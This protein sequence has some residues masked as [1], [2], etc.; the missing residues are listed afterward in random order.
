[1]GDGVTKISALYV[2]L[3]LVVG[4]VVATCFELTYHI[5]LAIILAGGILFLVSYYRMGA[6]VV[7]LLGLGAFMMSLDGYGVEPQ[8]IDSGGFIASLSHAAS[9]RLDA[10]ELSPGA[11]S[12][13]GALSL[14]ERWMLSAQELS[15]Y[16]RSGT[17]HFL[18][19]SGLHVAIVF[20]LLNSL[21]RYVALL[22]DGHL[23]RGVLS[24]S[25]IWLYAFVVGLPESVVRA[26]IMFTF[27]AMARSLSLPYV[28]LNVLGAAVFVMVI[29]SPMVVW[30][31]GFQLSVIAVAAIFLWA[32]P[33]CRAVEF[34]SPVA[35]WVLS[36]V[37]ISVC[38]TV[39]LAPLSALYFHYIPILGILFTPLFMLTAMLI[40][41]LCLCW[42]MVPIS[43]LA[44][45]VRLP[46]ELAAM[47]QNESARVV[48]SLEWGGIELS[49]T[50]D[51]AAI[52]YAIYALI[53]II[54]WQRKNI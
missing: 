27:Y 53:T 20:A 43:I 13:G 36:S 42:V 19:L 16:R 10:L 29:I 41:T 6:L 7:M 21:L 2:A 39:A 33:L 1:M 32:L 11:R 5:P 51:I 34:S 4:V 48:A 9:E 15:Y 31:V 17:A 46:I 12:V 26:A 52:A 47:I 3:S 44:P 50:P 45:L 54:V 37:I 23:I 40:L 18:A 28:G 14:G 30:S 35:E 22:R 38:C 8:S 25:F 24:V 49:I